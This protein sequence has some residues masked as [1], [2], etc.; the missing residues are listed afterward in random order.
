MVT[1]VDYNVG[2]TGSIANILRHIGIDSTV[3]SSL[4][5]VEKADKLI[6]P[7]VGS[8]DQGMENLEKLN[9]LPVLHK[10]V[11]EDKT[12]VLGICLGMQL[13]TQGSEEGRRP[14]LGWID[15]E[16]LRFDETRFNTQLRLPHMGWNQV[17]QQKTSDLF[18]PI[19]GEMR[20]YFVHTYHV[21][22][23]KP[24][25]VLTT[26][27]H[28]YDFVSSFQVEHIIGVQFHPEKS[29]RF[30]MDFMERFAGT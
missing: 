14:G 7:G 9:L 23:H 4:N 16:T 29:H 27:H 28:G 19:N 25:D 6:L 11:L 5:D 8:F 21:V 2:N 10:R 15:A 18:V 30:G 3:S 24:Q 22:C 13:M 20:F 17:H 1:I 12:P 26:T